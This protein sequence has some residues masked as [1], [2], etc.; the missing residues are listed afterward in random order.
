MI[1]PYSS[2]IVI[3]VDWAVP[4]SCFCIKIALFNGQI[5]H[6]ESNHERVK[7]GSCMPTCIFSFSLLSG[8]ET[9]YVI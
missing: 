1:A 9:T 3:K 5:F 7:C 8:T 4:G 6:N 2:G